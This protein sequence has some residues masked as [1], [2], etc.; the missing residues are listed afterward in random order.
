MSAGTSGSLKYSY[1]KGLFKLARHASRQIAQS[2]K[3]PSLKS[4]VRNE[5]L[6]LLVTHR[7][8]VKSQQKNEGILRVLI[9][10]YLLKHGL[11]LLEKD[12]GLLIAF[13]GYE[14]DGALI[15]FVDDYRHLVLV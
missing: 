7:H 11:R 15:Q 12:Q 4:N 5:P 14:I 10:L 2:S 13:L 9:R 6:L 3:I 8:V 1:R